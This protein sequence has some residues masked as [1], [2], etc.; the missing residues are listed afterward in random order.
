M[1]NK[2]YDLIIKNG[3]IFTGVESFKAD[4][5]IK[6][7]KIAGLLSNAPATTA[8]EAID[9]EGLF[10]F[11]GIIDSH[12]HFNEPGR[13]HWE[14]FATGSRSAAAGGVTTV[15]D[16]PLNST[17]CTLTRKELENKIRAGIENSIIDF[18]LWG[19]V[20]PANLPCLGELNSGGV[21]GFKGFLSDS[22]IDEFKNINDRE[23]LEALNRTGEMNALL[24]LHAENESVVAFFSNKFKEEGRTDP[25]AFLDSRPSLAEEEAVN[26][27]LFIKTRSSS[28]GR[29][30]FLHTTLPGCI[31]SINE[32]KREGNR[33]TVETCPHYLALTD[34]DFLKLGPVAKC[35]PPLR[36]REE[37]EALW[38]CLERGMVDVIGSDHSP[39]TAEEK[40]GN[41]WKA[42]G[43]ISGVQTMLSVVFTEG[44]KKRRLPFNLIVKMMSYNP[45]R[46]FTLYPKKGSLHPGSDADI[47]LFDPEGRWKVTEEKLFY[48][49]KL[50]PFMGKELYGVVKMTISRGEVIFREGDFEVKTG[51]GEY[52]SRNT[53]EE[54]V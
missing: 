24:G 3:V 33:I 9:A 43:G 52:L 26:R 36:S 8:E 20:T 48:K 16:M 44:V 35:A 50:S 46:I 54:S 12:V 40:E 17:P 53:V 7:E 49:N 15:I 28:K 31:E 19:G 2:R 45:A 29:L 47:V 41:I 30:H 34:R 13:E 18:A 37:V 5:C 42:W 39:C 27:A 32:S 23:L 21:V 51:R 14:G 4:I 1:E 38:K 11:P 10:V 6:E 22:G 25:Q